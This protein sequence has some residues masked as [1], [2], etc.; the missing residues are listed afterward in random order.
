MW[1]SL[2]DNI[3]SSSIFEC[4]RCPQAPPLTLT[5]YL[6]EGDLG[7]QTR[8]KLPQRSGKPNDMTNVIFLIRRAIINIT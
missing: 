7:F 3:S 6:W 8:I 2:T 4:G 1:L 5:F